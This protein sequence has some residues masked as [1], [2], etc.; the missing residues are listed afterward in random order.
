M[1]AASKK[2]TQRKSLLADQSLVF[3][4][5]VVA[6]ATTIIGWNLYDH[7]QTAY[8]NSTNL[9]S[10]LARVADEQISGSLRSVDL[11]LQDVAAEIPRMGSASRDAKVAYAKARAQTFPEI[12]QIFMADA[13]GMVQFT[14][15]PNGE[16]FNAAKRPFFS[17]PKNAPEEA[18]MHITGPVKV[19]TGDVLFFGS[20]ALIAADGSFAGVV[21]ASLSP[22]FFDEVLRSIIP[23]GNSADGLST[24][25]GDLLSRIPDPEKFR[26]ISIK[27]GQAFRT[28]VISD[29]Q[30]TVHHVTAITGGTE[31]LSVYRTLSDF[32][33]VVTVARDYDELMGP[34]R[35]GAL[36]HGL[37]LLIVIGITIAL[38]RVSRFSETR[39]RHE[40]ERLDESKTFFD[41]V[42][43]TANAMVVGLD[44][45]GKPV[46]FNSAAEEVTEYTLE[47]LLGR[48]WFETVVPRNRF[49]AH[50]EAIEADAANHGLPEVSEY[51]ILT[52][53]GDERFISWRNNVLTNPDGEIVTVSFGIDITEQKEYQARL[54][55]AN[56][57]LRSL[58]R[59]LER[60]NQEISKLGEMVELLQACQSF[61]EL[62]GITSRYAG[63]LFA[64][65]EGS[66]YFLAPSKDLLELVA[67]WP[68]EMKPGSVIIPDECWAVRKSRPHTSGG[69]EGVICDHLDLESGEHSLCVPMMTQGELIGTVVLK[70]KLDEPGQVPEDVVRLVVAVAEQVGLALSNLRLR[71]TLE[72]QALRDPL[73]MLYNRRYMSENF[74]RELAIAGRKEVPV[75]VIMLDVD[76]FK[77]F[78]DR[79]GHEAG[80]LVLKSVANLLRNQ[81][82]ASDIVCRYGGEEFLIILPDATLEM[83]LEKAEILRTQV[84]TMMVEFEGSVIDPVTL[85]F[86]VAV[87]P[88]NGTDPD[89]LIRAADIALYASKNAGRD[90]VTAAE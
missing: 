62:Y 54:V 70:N 75:S 57:R 64:E 43:E 76:K 52:K 71:E 67:Q 19:P 88:N 24:I 39:A 2:I 68:E 3:G 87:F 72:A 82:R 21:G 40:E 58:V 7:Y 86:G 47:E 30:T 83:G 14:T 78:N 50:W 59:A 25:N 81:C 15:L 26:A 89:N 22:E 10:N 35:L 56:A 13:A 5:F 74:Q 34:W 60:R 79:F 28:H 63:D 84:K 51:P 65:S 9:L 38:I 17:V 90:R 73:T 20:R 80:D 48:N 44:A 49:P 33:L 46:I 85:S 45:E 11:V 23:D 42:L 31:R 18:R 8:R 16:K 53:S 55:T 4:V 37:V 66:V 1:T 61:E 12:R 69:G 27:K 6:V 41:D 36:L 29:Q 77:P 32:P